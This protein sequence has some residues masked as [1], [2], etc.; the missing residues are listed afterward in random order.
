MIQACNCNCN[1]MEVAN[2]VL[3][4]APCTCPN[5]LNIGLLDLRKLTIFSPS[6]NPLISL[7]V[8]I[9]QFLNSTENFP[10]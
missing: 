5:H 3:K 6:S 10:F 2:V 8:L 1:G 4:L 7:F 9:H